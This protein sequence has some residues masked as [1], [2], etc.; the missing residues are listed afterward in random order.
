MVFVLQTIVERLLENLRTK[1]A[2]ETVGAC[3]WVAAAG[4][5]CD[6]DAADYSKWLGY[7]KFG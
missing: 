1:V 5:V 2:P 6:V 7:R 4:Y 3:L